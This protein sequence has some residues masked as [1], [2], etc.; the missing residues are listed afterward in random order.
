MFAHRLSLIRILGIDIG[1]DSS[2]ILF[3]A[4]IGWTLGKQIFP[5]VAPGLELNVYWWMA[6]AGVVG[7]MVSIIAHEMAHSLM[8]RRFGVPI[9]AITLFVFGGV[10]EM[11]SEPPTP[12]AE[13]WIALAGPIASL[14]LA[15]LL[16]MSAVGIVTLGCFGL[17]GVILVFR[18]PEVKAPVALVGA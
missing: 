10:A 8:A 9:N 6:A 18:L 1:I 4:L 7:L 12:E 17:L 16:E 3:A 14:V 11:D 15:L 5:D 2:W 13:I